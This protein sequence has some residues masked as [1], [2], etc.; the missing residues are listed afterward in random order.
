MSKLFPFLDMNSAEERNRTLLLFAYNFLATSIVVL[1]RIA[2]DTLFLNK[3]KGDRLMLSFMYICVAVLVSLATLLYTKRSSF[4]RMDKL[5]TVTLSIGF[6]LT[7]TFVVLISNEVSSAFSLLYIFMELL[8]AFTMFQFWS[9]TNELLDSREAK[10]VLGFVGCGGIIATLIVGGSVGKLAVML[11]KVQYLLFINASSMLLCIA[12]VNVMGKKYQS[13]LQK[14]VVAKSFFVRQV[15][16]AGRADM[17]KTPYIRSI[18]TMIAL[19]YVAVTLV[20]YQFKVVASDKI[21]DPQTLAAYF[22]LIYSIFGGVFSLIFQLMAT[23]RLLKFSIFI[24]LGILPAI[25]TLSS[26]FFIAV[27]EELVIFG[28]AAPL[29]AITM[30]KSG[31]SAFRYT[32]NDAAIQLLYIPLDPKIKSRVKALVDGM[33]KPIFIGVSGLILLAVS[34]LGKEGIVA[35]DV[36]VISWVVIATGILWLATIVGIRSRYLSVL[37]DNIRKKRFGSNQLTMQMNVFQDIVRKAIDS[38]DDEDLALAI[39]MVESVDDTSLGRDFVALL[40]K[41]APKIKVKILVLMRRMESR[42]NIYNILK[43]FNDP[44]EE[45]VREAILT[46]GY[47]QMEKSIKRIAPFLESDKIKIREAAVIALIKYAGVAGAMT[48]GAYLK[49]FARSEDE[50]KRASAAYILGELGQK[51]MDQQ[52]FTFLNDRSPNVRRV[53][54]TA[55]SKIN[56]NVF[57]PKLFYMLIDKNVG[58]DAAKVLAGLGEKI[59]APAADILSNRLESY[60]LKSEVAKMLGD[61]YTQESFRLLAASLETE[62]DEMRNIIL[63]SMKKLLSKIENIPLDKNELK[64]LLLKE[65]YQY[66]QTLYISVQIQRKFATDCLYDVTKTK[67]KNCYQRIFSILS[68]MYGNSLFDSIYF[69]I[70]RKFVS[71]TQRANAL[72]IVDTIVDKEIRP[73]IVPLIESRDEEEKLNL[74]FT[75][76]NIKQMEI[77]DIIETFMTD[78]SEWVRS[79]TLYA[80]SYEHLVEFYSKI[81]MFLYDPSPIVREA[82]LYA[83]NFLN[84]KIADSDADYLL[85]DTDGFLCRYAATVLKKV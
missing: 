75:F 40:S 16:T 74:G 53:A 67:L 51:N 85:S 83:M 62:S 15:K 39:D 68:L 26:F 63:N 47:S 18:A 59:L 30:A 52:L 14:S 38:G 65:I 23:S 54:V 13:R 84:I 77:D 25:I 31:D 29:F 9:F 42:Y 4:Y 20:D 49:A 50:V 11:G 41:A 2:R 71:P 19:I 66:F 82:A 78:D 57:I 32:I 81:Q 79:L 76:F 22:G 37:I 21:S 36:R 28:F 72:E 33:V 3:Y 55:A 56:S 27:P 69:N 73:I 60:R 1:G 45:V 10:R 17:V 48:A 61:I 64:R 12:I 46:Y 35:S 6:I 80:V 70:T 44:D 58:F 34:Y 8:G 43:L 5:I 7:L 24:S